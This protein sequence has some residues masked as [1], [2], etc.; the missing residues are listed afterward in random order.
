MSTPRIRRALALVALAA[1]AP[2]GLAACGDDD[3]T[4]SDTTEATDAEPGGG[5][6]DLA[7]YC[8][9]T[10]EIETLPEPDVDFE[11]G[12]EEEIAEGIKSYAAEVMRPVA[13][14]IVENVPEENADNI[15]ILSAGVDE[16]AE[17]GDFEAV[18]G[19]EEREAASDRAH[20][21]DLANCDWVE[22][23]VN[24]VDYAFEGVPGT[25][26]AGITSFEFTNSGEEEH[27]MVV[28]RK[29][30]DATETMEEILQLPEEEGQ[31]KVTFVAANGASPG[32][33]EYA[34]ADLESG[35]YAMVCFIPVGTVGETEGDGPPH[36]TQGMAS[37]FTVS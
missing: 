21:F 15:A 5:D 3:E 23:P 19:S 6:G 34:I 4:S 10:E 24:A 33:S 17:T 2:A 9:A 11:N 35:E 26:E 1:L 16:L 36:F 32:G 14:R 30:A 27:E 8:E 13:D 31:S 12:S 22:Q 25:L 7:A 37:Y 18:F 28:I 29:N 20:E